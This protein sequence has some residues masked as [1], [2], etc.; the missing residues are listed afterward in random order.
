MT[1]SVPEATLRRVLTM[2]GIVG[3]A[4]TL[5]HAGLTALALTTGTTLGSTA[6]ALRVMTYSSPPLAVPSIAILKTFG[7]STVVICRRCTSDTR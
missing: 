7:A 2:L 6:E 3:L 4:W 1:T 5:L